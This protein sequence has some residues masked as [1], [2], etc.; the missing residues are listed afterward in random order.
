MKKSYLMLAAVA[1]ILASCAQNE[2]IN[3]DLKDNT[4]PSVIGFSSFSEKASKADNGDNT[5]ILNLEY[6]HSKFAV[7]AT[8]QSQ[9]DNSVEYVFGGSAATAAGAKKVQSAP[10]QVMTTPH[11]TVQTG[12]TLIPVIGT[13]RPVTSS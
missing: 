6:F 8:K 2:Q 3:S 4:E 11:S 1:T 7:Y 13:S 5:N 12:A 10:T 9:V